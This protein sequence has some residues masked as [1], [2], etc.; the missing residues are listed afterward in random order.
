MGLREENGDPVGGEVVEIAQEPSLTKDSVVMKKVQ[1][2]GPSVAFWE[3]FRYADGFD[4]FLIVAGTVGAVASGLSLPVLLVIQAKLLNSFGTLHGNE[5][6]KEACKYALLFVYASMGSGFAAYV[7][8]TCWM[9][10]GERQSARIRAKYLRATLR[11]DVGYFDSPSSSTAEVVNNVAADATL[12]QEAMSEKVGNYV[13]NMTTFLAGYAVSFFLVWRLALI[14]LPFLPLLLVPGAYYN[15]A[16]SSLA[17]RMQTSYNI[18]GGIVEQALSS[19]RTVYSFVAE[20]G[21][22]K[23][24]SESLDSTLKLGLK[25]GY[26]KGI[27][28]GSVGLCYAIWALMAWYGSEEVIK[29]HAQGGIVIVTGFLLVHGGM[30]LG[31]AVPFYKTMGEGCAAAFRIFE[32]IKRDP[33]I[34]ADDMNGQ[35]LEKVVGNLELR[36]VDFAYP[37]RLDVPVLQK[38]CLKIPAGKTVALVG[39]SGSGKSTVIALFERFYDASA[40]E[41]LLDGVDIKNLQLK[42]LRQQMGLVSQEPA[43]FA[44]SIKEN[45]MYG[46]DNATEDEV[47]EAA[48]SA[49]AFNFI[50]ELPEG[51]D[52]QVGERGVQMSGG[53]KQRIA[54][55]RAL[56]RNPPVMLLD[57]ATSALDAESEKVVQEA[58]ERAALG[59]TTVVVA[60]RLSSISNA[61]VIAVIQSGQVLEMGSHEELLTKG[62][63]YAA[64]IQL[65]KARHEDQTPRDDDMKLRSSD[66]LLGEQSGRIS[67]E[68]SGNSEASVKTIQKSREAVTLKA[69]DRNLDTTERKPQKP[70]LPSMRRLLALNKPEWKQGL[71]GVAGAIGFGFVQPIYA[72]TIG[73]LLGSFYSKDSAKLRH[74]VKMN[75]IV[76]MSLA[77]F[78]F[79]VNILQ[80]YNFADLGERLTKRIRV[81]MLTNILRFEVGWYDK[82]ENASGAICSRLATDAN[83]I[84]GLVGDRISLI[85]GTG[86]AIAV[87]FGLGLYILW[88]LALV[89]IS[90]QPLII[91]SF[92]FK[93]VLLT[94]FAMETVKAQQGA[95]QVAS[96]AVAQ[97]RTVTAF[98]AQDKV[99]SLFE[100]KLE[101]PRREV[102]KR[103]H[104]AGACLGAS[105]LVLY[106][107]WGL[108]FWYGGRLASQEKATFTEVFQVFMVLVS[109]GRLLAEAGTLTP[110]IAKGSAAAASVFEI[111][112][113]DTSINPTEPSDQVGKVEGHID[114]RNVTFSYP[115]RPN[116]VVFQ[117]FSLTVRAGS[118]VAMVGQSGSGKSTII[119]LIERFY[120]PSEGE[121]L[122]DGKNIKSMNLRSLRSHI[123]L[124]SQEPTLFAGTLRQNI[125]YGRENATEE[126]IIE[127]SRAANA[128]NFIS[129]LPMGYD[130]YAGE[131]GVQL[132]GGQKQRIAIAR[133]VLKNPAILLLDEATSALDAA[134]ER[135]VQDAL[136]RM[137]VGRTT[138]VVAHRCN[139]IPPPLISSSIYC[140]HTSIK[141][142]LMQIILSHY[143]ANT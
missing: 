91:L 111:L 73:D 134:S 85:V 107:S 133:A 88:P 66:V 105:D 4:K 90:V 131:R 25:Q 8:T 57:E 58:L 34:D 69:L 61:D 83:T 15:R 26:A 112:D 115:S 97:H 32:L 101:K 50:D 132:S 59:R 11:Q 45:I 117:D 86:S 120:D 79:A 28:I 137:M 74:D 128:H 121:I 104:I 9:C 89:V 118:T 94:Q 129:S 60:H 110:D 54:I 114:V 33:P 87:S 143:D 80:H 29:G 17:L 119:G 116:V 52:T 100:A 81:R 99:L 23:A 27:A 123:G 12:V 48:K 38:F 56:L 63:G 19:V 43:L 40:G 7:E 37:T 126:E 24:Y 1:G 140:M 5:L 70:R 67:D 125:A 62:G 102:M 68:L 72:Y 75:V 10:T 109:S 18:A 2:A 46:K 30:A 78:A 22:V 142:I 77:V 14:V 51:F 20:D 122:I 93:K 139:Q 53:Q 31:N 92:Y 76:L 36:N 71:L 135:I 124:V 96:E 113:R 95:S 106:A 138:I 35:T 44:T 141:H 64:L 65:H 39:Q 127:A 47:I 108:D 55:A 130:T 84:R 3:L 98:S 49:N 6:Y 136:D 21:T 41:V 13:K 16:I 82:D 42:W 103:A